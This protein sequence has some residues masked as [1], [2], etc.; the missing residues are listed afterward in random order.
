MKVD[1]D[2]FT[3]TQQRIVSKLSDGLP[4]STVEM[5]LCLDDKLSDI[6][7]LR[8]HISILRRRL[9]PI[10]QDVVCQRIDG[11]SYYRLIRLTAS[12]YDGYR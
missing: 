2:M 11:M 9:R 12:P 1:T 3:P 7:C 4:H 10:G 8:S 5:M 6:T